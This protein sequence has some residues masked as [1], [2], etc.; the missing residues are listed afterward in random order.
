M[1]S[2]FLSAQIKSSIIY[3]DYKSQVPKSKRWTI[4]TTMINQTKPNE[5][6]PN[7]IKPNETKNKIKIQGK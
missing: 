7:E 4:P 3:D 2:P 5:T 6:K 1:K